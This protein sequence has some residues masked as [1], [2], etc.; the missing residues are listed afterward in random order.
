MVRGT[1]AAVADEF[2]NVDDVKETPVD[3]VIEQLGSS[4]DGLSADEAGKRLKQYGAN[5]LTTRGES[6]LHKLLMFFWGPIPWMIEAAAVLSI[7]VGD[8]EDLGIILFLLAFNAIIGFTEENRA[9]NALNALKG[10]LALKARVKREGKWQDV[11]ADT[12]V[13]GDIV[14]LKLGDVIPADC[15]LIDGDYISIDQASLTGESLPVTKKPGDVAYSGSVAKQGEMVA[16]VTTTG[17]HTFFGRTARLVAGAGIKSSLQRN[18]ERYSDYLI[19]L[20]LALS[21]VLI[22]FSVWRDFELGGFQLSDI[23]RLVNYVLL[24][25]IA[26]IPVATP[27]VVSV[28][29]ALGAVALSK[30]KAIVSRLQ[31]IEEMASVDILCSDKTG[32]LTKNQLTLQDPVLFGADDAQQCILAGSLASE[33]GSEDAIDV[34]VTSALKDKKELDRYDQT[35]FTPFDPVSKRTSATV[36]GPDGSVRH[37]AKGAPEVLITDLCKLHGDGKKQAEHTVK[38]LARHG[39]RALAVADSDDGATWR[40][41]GILPMYDPPRDDSKKT[42]KQAHKLGLDVKMITGDDTKIGKQIARQIGIGHHIQAAEDVFKGVDPDHVPDRLAEAIEKADGFGRVFPEHK[43]AIVKAL[44][45]RGH[46]VAMTGDGVNDAPALKQANCGVAVSGATEA[47]QAAAALV[48]TLPGLHVIIGAIKAARQIFS[49][50]MSYS[51]Y[52]VAMSIDIMVF[53]VLAMLLFPTIK[54][55][56]GQAMIFQPITAVMIIAI[57]LLDDIPMIAIAYDNTQISK[58]PVHWDMRRMLIVSTV[59]GLLSVAQ[60][61]GIMMWGIANLN[62]EVLG[63]TMTAGAIQSLVFLQLIVGGGLLLFVTRTEG[64]LLSNPRPSMALT[65]ANLGTKLIAVLMCAFG[66]FVPEISWALIGIVWAYDIV[67]MFVLDVVKLG[68]FA[69]LDG[70]IRGRRLM[71]LRIERGLGPYRGFH[72]CK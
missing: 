32:T 36:K 41:L 58:K 1:E 67:W 42:I 34:A 55:P 21:I 49:R 63:T 14:Q 11:A 62:K 50:I 35:S 30:K 70:K 65:A 53:V 64:S 72:Q 12:L 47:A 8:W 48:L 33:A 27:T 43:Y 22:G 61:F 56:S 69:A 24:L 44:Q 57:A 26:T 38:K 2:I 25:V 66:W 60:T 59:L 18:I 68:T 39:Y 7:I 31:A 52:R 4:R 29:L 17:A 71:R 45:E 16:L 15:K 10:A 51:I 19:Y 3:D 13:P 40:L 37:Y 23:L 6:R 5:A 54:D 46:T 20:A 9:A 28:T